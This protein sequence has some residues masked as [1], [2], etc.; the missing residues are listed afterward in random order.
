MAGY[1]H[2]G[3]ETLRPLY[4]DIENKMRELDHALEDWRKAVERDAAKTALEMIRKYT[5]QGV[6]DEHIEYVLAAHLHDAVESVRYAEEK[7]RCM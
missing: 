4:D 7:R 3:D 2:W 1:G 5:E 6:P